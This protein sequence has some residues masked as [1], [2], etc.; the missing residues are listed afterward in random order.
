MNYFNKY[1]KYK[2]KYLLIKNNININIIGGKKKSSKIRP[3]PTDSATLYNIGTKK[4]GN[5]GNIWIVVKN[6]NGVK[7]WK[8]TKEFDISKLQNKYDFY[9]N[10]LSKNE[11]KK[12]IKYLKKI[13]K[14]YDKKIKDKG[15]NYVLEK[16]HKKFTEYNNILD[17]VYGSWDIIKKIND[18]VNQK[19]KKNKTIT[20]IGIGDSPTIFLLTYKKIYGI[21]KNTKIQFLPISRLHSINDKEFYIGVDRFLK[22]NNLIKTDYVLW[23]DYVSSGRTIY[24]FID[25]LPQTIMKKSSFFLYGNVGKSIRLPKNKSIKKN[26]LW[27]YSIPNESYFAY[28]LATTIGQSE[29]YMMRCVNKK[30]LNKDYKVEL[31]NINKLPLQKDLFG[32][33]CISFSNYLY[34]LIKYYYSN[35]YPKSN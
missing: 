32:K 24:N 29:E 15:Y 5:D 33:H 18:H 23:V 30:K 25:M 17:I 1:I 13:S 8:K 4:E 35:N 26:N 2:K 9:E 12:L 27:L 19:I 22:I 31:F 7:R 28:F 3:S 20:I 34:N 6:K 16:T 11:N 14:I 10:Y 21:N